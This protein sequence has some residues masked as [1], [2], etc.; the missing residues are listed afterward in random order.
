MDC[1]TERVIELM[2]VDKKI[3]VELRLAPTII[4]V[5]LGGGG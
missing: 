1:M 4:G 5:E 3:V 2:R